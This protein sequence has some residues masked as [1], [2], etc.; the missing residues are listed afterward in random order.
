MAL[1]DALNAGPDISANKYHSETPLFESL[2]QAL[3]RDPTRLDQIARTVADLERS[4]EG[5]QLLPPGFHAV[6]APIWEA[7]Q[8]LQS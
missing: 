6:W 1:L 5:A 3:Q 4:P 2:V 8:R 7:R